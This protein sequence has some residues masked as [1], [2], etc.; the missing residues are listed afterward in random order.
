MSPVPYRTEPIKPKSRARYVL[1]KNYLDYY[2]PKW[3]L[4]GKF[5]WFWVA[6]MVGI[7]HLALGADVRCWQES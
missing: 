2:G 7:L 3:E 5:R 4:I 1:E 6:R